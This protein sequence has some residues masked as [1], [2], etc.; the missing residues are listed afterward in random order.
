[1]M[2]PWTSAMC[3]LP[4][5]LFQN[6]TMRNA[7]SALGRSATASTLDADLVRAETLAVVVPIALDQLFELSD[8]VRVLMRGT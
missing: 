3:S 8:G 5:R 6:A 4:S 1:M 2:S 7:R